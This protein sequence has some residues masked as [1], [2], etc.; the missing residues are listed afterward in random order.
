MGEEGQ[1]MEE[2]KLPLPKQIISEIKKYILYTFKK[3]N[4][5]ITSQI[6]INSPGSHS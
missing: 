3:S 5:V 4:D 1:I 2:I 6:L